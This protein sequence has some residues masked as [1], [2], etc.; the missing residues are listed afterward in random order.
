M[1]PAG[2]AWCGPWFPPGSPDSFQPGVASPRLMAFGPPLPSSRVPWPAPG[3]P[4]CGDASTLAWAEQWEA[5]AAEAGREWNWASPV[6]AAEHHPDGP[7]TAAAA[8]RLRVGLARRGARLPQTVAASRGLWGPAAVA[9]MEAWRSFD[10]AA[11]PVVVDGGNAE[12]APSSEARPHGMSVCSSPPSRALNDNVASSSAAPAVANAPRIV[13]PPPL[14]GSRRSRDGRCG[15]R[16]QSVAQR[17]GPRQS[18]SR[19]PRLRS[20]SSPPSHH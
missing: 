1:A 2:G 4:V 10:S 3:V 13:S 16:P 15:L 5:E 7:A 11:A 9:E 14:P 6:C 12:R 8:A 17:S 18:R 20:R 19:S